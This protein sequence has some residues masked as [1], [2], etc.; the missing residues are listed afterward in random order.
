[1][2]PWHKLEQYS[3]VQFQQKGYQ[4]RVGWG[5]HVWAILSPITPLLSHVTEL[6]LGSPPP[7]PPPA[8]P[9]APPCRGGPDCLVHNVAVGGGKPQITISQQVGMK[10]GLTWLPLTQH[11][12]VVIFVPGVVV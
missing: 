7:P 2:P 4:E 6:Y 1:M 5:G 3:T 10:E 8:A 11:L 12:S 9:W